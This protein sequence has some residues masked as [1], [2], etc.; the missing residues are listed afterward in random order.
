MNLTPKS[1]I[2]TRIS[3]L[4]N[5]LAAKD[6]DGAIILLNSDLFYFTGTVQASYLFMP[7][8]GEP[9]LMI[10][11]SLRRGKEESQLKNIEPIKS[12][13]K[14]PD[15]LASFGFTN[16][17]KIGLELDVLPVNIYQIY[18]RIFPNAELFDISPFIK[19]VR[20]VKSPY[21]IKLLKNTLGVI[22]QAFLAVPSFLREGMLEIELA[23]LFEGE[24]RKR[25]YSGWCKMRSFNQDFFLGNICTG[26]S[27]ACPGYFD[28]PVGGSGVSVSQP[29]GAGWKRIKRDEV[30]Y[31]DYTCVIDGYTGDQ[32]RIFCIGELSPRMVKAFKDALII[33]AEILK[34]IKPGTP[35]EE[36]Y[37]LSVK[38]AEEMGYRDNFMGYQDDQVKFIGHGIGLELDEWPILAKGIKTP[39]VPGMTFALEPKFVFPEGAIGTENSFVM[40]ETGPQYL[41]IT[42][43]VITYLK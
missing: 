12:P 15:V 41:S 6:L 37:L 22:D 11:K 31:I 18:Q 40:T 3:L 19:E 16:L 21:E 39:L 5:K 2:A 13:K 26:E 4:Q 20:A 14:I 8:S 10:K 9:V 7:A 25:G 24:M 27:G 43:E 42:P 23:A 33:E 35:A 17:R 29:Q 34:T 30:V 38:L 32:T 28:G 36:P 1:E